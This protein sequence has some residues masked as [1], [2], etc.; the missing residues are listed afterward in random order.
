MI[1]TAAI[2]GVRERAD[3]VACCAALALRGA[4][5]GAPLVIA[6]G[7]PERRPALL[8]SAAATEVEEGINAAG[9]GGV[10]AVARGHLCI[11]SVPGEGGGEAITR[12]RE[13]A[14]EERV[15]VASAEPGGLE[16]WQRSITLIRADLP[17]DREVLALL[18]DSLEAEA[19]A[20]RVDKRGPGRIGARRAL[21]GLEPGRAPSARYEWL[22]R[23]V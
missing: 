22:C 19:G 3:S 16:L 1:A 15:V 14:G 13:I 11:V 8:A 5:R 7:G 17:A 20:L 4:G 9:L 10:A 21:A 18:A 6:Q 23:G 12:I 2:A